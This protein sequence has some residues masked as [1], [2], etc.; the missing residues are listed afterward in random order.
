M[1]RCP[2]ATIKQVEDAIFARE[3]FRVKLEPLDPKIKS[4]PAYDHDY[5]AYNK[6][7][8][9]EWQMVRL[10]PYVAHLRS[11]TVLRPDG[12]R[13]VSDMQIGNLRDAYFKE[14]CAGEPL[15]PGT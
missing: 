1:Y 3:G 7:K 10:A 8:L 14:L 6:W 15:K 11:V 9:T 4:I 13:T 2:M 12:A 5:M